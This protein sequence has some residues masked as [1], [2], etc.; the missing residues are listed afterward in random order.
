MEHLLITRYNL[1]KKDWN[2]DRYG[3]E[4]LT[5]EWHENREQLFLQLCLPSVVAQRSKDFR[6][7]VFFQTDLAHLV[8]TEIKNS[9]FL[10]PI[11]VDSYE[12]FESL[13]VEICNQV[14]GELITSRLDN[15]DALKPDFIGRVQKLAKA[16]HCIDFPVGERVYLWPRYKRE[17]R[18]KRYN[19]FISLCEGA[20][21][22]AG[23]FHQQHPRYK[24]FPTITSSSKPAWTE[25]IHASNKVNR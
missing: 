24:T 20:G 8:S 17:K 19:Q 12:Q 16:G 7:L 21:V 11:F 14:S 6:W 23:V 3:A 13:L 9:P 4:V 15:D 25:F 22:K 1:R 2:R 18:V 10:I 5:E